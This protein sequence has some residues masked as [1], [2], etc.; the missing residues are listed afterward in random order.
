MIG[1]L[2]VMS[3]IH[4]HVL[5]KL[6]IK[7]CKDKMSRAFH[8]VGLKRHFQRYSGDCM[9]KC[10]SSPSGFHLVSDNNG[11]WRMET[12]SVHNSQANGVAFGMGNIEINSTLPVLYTACDTIPVFFSFFKWGMWVKRHHNGIKKKARGIEKGKREEQFP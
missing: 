9:Q 8:C 11:F 2:P 10:Q 4:V 6:R 3:L 5:H 7:E 12:R 1:Y